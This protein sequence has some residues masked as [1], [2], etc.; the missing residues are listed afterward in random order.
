MEQLDL[1]DLSKYIGN[2][3]DNN[4]SPPENIPSNI[5]DIIY[6]GDCMELLKQISENSVDLVF[7][8]PPYN[9]GKVKNDRKSLED[10]FNWQKDVLTECYRVLKDTGSLFWQVGTFVSNTGYNLPLDYRFFPILEDLNMIPRNRIIWIRPHGVHAKNKFSG[11]H[12]TILWFTKT[13]N[14]KFFL[15]PIKVPQKYSNK[16]YWKGDKK[17]QF[18][19]DP[20]G[21]NPGDV[22]AFRNVRH[23]HDEDT[24]HPTQFPEDIVERALLC[25]TLPGDIVLDPFMGV[26]TTAVVA[27]NF[28]RFF[29]GAEINPEY[30]EIAN[31][32]LSKEPDENG[33]F[34]NLKTLR[35]YV[36]ERNIQNSSKFTFTR[37][38]KGTIPSIDSK[39]Y[40]EEYHQEEIINRIEYEAENIVY[41]QLNFTSSEND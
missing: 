40:T 20:L 16:K 34:P 26:G 7:S 28:N 27:K 1:F 4:I 35:E 10:Y 18:S 17:G 33:N 31:Q 30:V 15:E 6:Q 19:C 5:L 13:M 12:E 22:W 24:I 14:Y 37:Q 41:K 3:E 29:C 9:I 2:K 38:R 32:R 23:N 39:A 25:T 8:S 36:K 11:R 21:K